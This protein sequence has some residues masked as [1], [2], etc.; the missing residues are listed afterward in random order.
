MK[1][2]LKAD[3][4]GKGKAGDLINVAE[5][6]GRNFLLPKGLAVI[7]DAKAM[8]EHKN[9]KESEAFKQK[10]AQDNAKA[11]AAQLE[12]KTITINAKAGASGRLFGSVTTSEISD[13]IKAQTGIEIDKRKIVL[14]KDIKNYG[15]YTVTIKLYT[16]I[17][18]EVSVNICE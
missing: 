10:Q 16:G 11:N 8:N 18:A 1:V 2:I 7:A 17:S 9:Q 15:V 13:A 5:G 14:D 6:Y 4:K 3:V 12:G